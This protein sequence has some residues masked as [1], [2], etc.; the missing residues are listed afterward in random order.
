MSNPETAFTKYRE[1]TTEMQSGDD[2]ENDEQTP[3][4]SLES[5]FEMLSVQGET[6]SV[7]DTT[8]V[9]DETPTMTSLAIESSPPATSPGMLDILN[10]IHQLSDDLTKKISDNANSISKVSD[11]L[12]DVKSE[13]EGKMLENSNRVQSQMTAFQREIANNLSS[14]A[15]SQQESIS[16]INAKL[17]AFSSDIGNVR[18]EIHHET[19]KVQNNFELQLETMSR[20]KTAEVNTCRK[21]ISNIREEISNVRE[22]VT[23][24]VEH[25]IADLKGTLPRVEGEVARLNGRIAEL[26]SERPVSLKEAVT[27]VPVTKPVFRERHSEHPLAFI[28]D[29]ED[30]FKFTHTLPEHQSRLAIYL[31][32]GKAKMWSDSL[33]PIPPTYAEFK[34]KFLE[35]YWDYD[36]RYNYKMK[37][38]TGKYHHSTHGS[39]KEYL[40]R[41]IALARLSGFDLDDP[42]LLTAIIKQF[43]INIQ[44]LIRSAGPVSVE[45]LRQLLGWYDHSAESPLAWSDRHEQKPSVKH[46]R[47]APSSQRRNFT[48]RDIQESFNITPPERGIQNRTFFNPPYSHSPHSPARESADSRPRG[49][50]NRPVPPLFTTP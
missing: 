22:E 9:K 11:D 31:L 21:E 26:G 7:P 39:M 4:R 5:H 47:E 50:T 43:P 44:D 25:E 36:T 48:R 18:A 1:A 19:R 49:Q 20:A 42:D 8:E 45:R 15:A 23:A 17:E 28:R 34:E 40:T 33:D 29:L 2:S 13:L 16:S 24:H 10:A 46:M 12:K 32:E 27:P 37:V 30:Y 41:K 35:N 3:F 6:D 14:F 38:T